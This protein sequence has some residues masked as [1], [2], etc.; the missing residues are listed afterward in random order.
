[1]AAS[2]TATKS[3]LLD[4]L[5]QDNRQGNEIVSSQNSLIVTWLRNLPVMNYLDQVSESL[6]AEHILMV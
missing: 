5:E 3:A 4:G 1:M 6:L 2:M